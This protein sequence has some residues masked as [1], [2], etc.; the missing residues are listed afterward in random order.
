MA[1]CVFTT[2]LSDSPKWSTIKTIAVNKPVCQ[3]LPE[4]Q[5]VSQRAENV[6]VW[7]VLAKNS[8]AWEVWCRGKWSRTEPQELIPMILFGAVE[9]E[10][11][12]TKSHMR[13]HS[14][15]TSEYHHFTWN[16]NT[17]NH[18]ARSIIGL[19]LILLH[20]GLHSCMTSAHKVLPPTLESSL[21][22]DWHFRSSSLATP[23]K[24]LTGQQLIL[25][26]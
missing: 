8:S 23:A 7:W 17:F 16:G 10:T 3:W 13:R 12:T 25:D 24:H 26:C 6:T 18:A 22:L 11:N 20:H 21:K 9:K 19:I 1:H 4:V 2:L 15:F 5:V 14:I